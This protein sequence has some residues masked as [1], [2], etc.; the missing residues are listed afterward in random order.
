MVLVFEVIKTSKSIIHFVSL[1]YLPTI[2]SGLGAFFVSM[3]LNQQPA[4]EQP[5]AD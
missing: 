5:A 2:L 1:L 3:L 4:A